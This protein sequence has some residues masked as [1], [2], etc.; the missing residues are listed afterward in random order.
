LFACRCGRKVALL[1]ITFVVFTYVQTM[2]SQNSSVDEREISLGEIDLSLAGLQ[3]LMHIY[4]LSMAVAIFVLMVHVPT[5]YCVLWSLW[6]LAHIFTRRWMIQRYDACSPERRLERMEFWRLAVT[7]SAM[8]YG[9]ILGSAA[10]IGFAYSPL[11]LKVFWTVAIMVI[12]SA[13]TSLSSMR[14]KYALLI[15]SL[16]PLVSA[17]W[18]WGGLIAVP[19]TAGIGACTLVYLLIGQQHSHSNRERIAK[20][21]RNEALTQVITQRNQILDASNQFRGALLTAASHDLRQPVQ[22]L[23]MMAALMNAD[24]PA[25]LPRRIASVRACVES[26]SEMLN[27]L[28]EYNRLEQGLQTLQIQPLA[29]S[30]LL[31]EVRENFSAVAEQKGLRLSVRG[32]P[33][34]IQTDAHILRRMLFN[35]V[36]NAV[37]YTPS[38]H[39]RVECVLRQ[40]VVHVTVVDSGIGIAAER[41]DDIFTEYVRLSDERAEWEEGLGLG[42]SIVRKG[43][44]LLGQQVSVTSVLGQGSCFTLSL[45]PPLDTVV[46]LK[47]HTEPLPASVL[48]VAVAVV[49]NDPAVLECLLDTFKTWGCKPVGGRGLAQIECEL[50]RLGVVPELVVTDLHLSLAGTGIQVIERLRCVYGNP[51]LPAILLTGDLDPALET[52]AHAAGIL[53]AHKP[54][55]PSRMRLLMQKALTLEADLPGDDFKYQIGAK[56][57]TGQA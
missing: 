11:E 23:S 54:L 3:K 37:R 49:E 33:V 6:C 26:L 38:G 34:R 18:L 13:N 28:L 19:V 27:Q 21:L 53:L 36:S 31:D 48:Q 43:A 7:V 57:T 8:W 1:I 4:L 39:V 50:A 55:H 5:L 17:W 40:G 2:G 24:D 25:G 10:L 12:Y 51:T 56:E 41:L 32:L 22:A 42:L 46:A 45:G 14:Q 16:P 30:T 20:G 29:L 9:S 35:L 47:G 15:T 52:S 44:D